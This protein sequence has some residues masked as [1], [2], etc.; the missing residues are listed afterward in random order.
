M[1]WQTLALYGAGAVVAIAI[2]YIA[3]RMIRREARKTGADSEALETL[4]KVLEAD[5]KSHELDGRPVP[6]H[7]AEQQRRMRALQARLARHRGG[8]VSDDV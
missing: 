6:I 2:V 1:G 8:E 4:E 7:L 3:F 5:E